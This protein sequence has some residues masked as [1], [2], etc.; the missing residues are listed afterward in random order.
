[1]RYA[2]AVLS[3]GRVNPHF[4]RAKKIALV[5]VEAGT[6]QK[7]EE[8]E[9]TYAAFHPGHHGNHDHH[10][11][12]HEHHGHE[13]HD[14]EHHDH[15]HHD[16]EHHGRPAS[17][18]MD[19]ERLRHQEAIRDFLLDHHVDILLLDH[20]GPGIARVLSDTDIKVVTGIKGMAKDAVLAADR[21]VRTQGV[22]R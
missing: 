1:M 15:E 12:D 22:E 14:H 11:H 6:I 3:S 5:D 10:D 7:W 8:V 21:F 2:V 4:G 18:R 9:A 19:P 16:H 17:G 13:H 20:A